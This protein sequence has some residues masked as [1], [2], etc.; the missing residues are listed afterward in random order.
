MKPKQL[1]LTHLETCREHL[2]HKIDIWMD[3]QK[4]IGLDHYNVQEDTA[5]QTLA[6]VSPISTNTLSFCIRAL[7]DVIRFCWFVQA[8]EILVTVSATLVTRGWTSPCA[9]VWACS[10]AWPATTDADSCIIRIE[11]WPALGSPFSSTRGRTTSKIVR[12]MNYIITN[13][14]KYGTCLHSGAVVGVV[15]TPPHRFPICQGTYFQTG[16]RAIRW[17]ES[18]TRYPGMF[19]QTTLVRCHVGQLDIHKSNLEPHC[20]KEPFAHLTLCVRWCMSPATTSTN[21]FGLKCFNLMLGNG[22]LVAWTTENVIVSIGTNT[23]MHRA[24]SIW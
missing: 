19:Y 18:S 9:D 22:K 12:G 5:N 8:S 10:T 21:A 13:S 6:T 1:N 24:H 15:A 2:P 3:L 11:S 23:D 14:W 4:P 17:R 7:K 16:Y 20:T